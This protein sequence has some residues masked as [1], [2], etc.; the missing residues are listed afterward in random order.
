MKYYGYSAGTLNGNIGI[1]NNRGDFKQVNGQ[2]IEPFP[3]Y[4]SL[5][6]VY[7]SNYKKGVVDINANIV[8]NPIYD[9]IDQKRNYFF[10]KL[11]GKWGVVDKFNSVLIP[12]NFFGVVQSS[13]ETLK[14]IS[15]KLHKDSSFISYEVL[16]ERERFAK[17]EQEEARR[18]EEEKKQ[19][20]IQMAEEQARQKELKKMYAELQSTTINYISRFLKNPDGAS[21]ISYNG[22]EET[23]RQLN[24]SRNYL[25]NCD[26]VFATM[27]TVDATNSFGGYIRSTYIVFFKD[28]YPCHFEDIKAI[29]KA[30]NS[31]SR[32]GDM[33]NMLSLTLQLNGCG[34]R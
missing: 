16:Q 4:E 27:I 17:E 1:I 20:K 34:C 13:G 11:N 30:R 25:P 33:N 26:N 21:W 18:V 9:Y 15:V 24:E 5:Y 32:V 22:P 28:N 31:A 12:I 8:I 6:T 2:S 3:Y 14:G 23:R 29:D 10:V 19:R 7:T